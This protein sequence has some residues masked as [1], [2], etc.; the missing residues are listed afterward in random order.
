KDKGLPVDLVLDLMDQICAGVAVA[1]RNAMVHR[2]LKPSNIFLAN[3]SGDS[4]VVKVL[5]FGIAKLVDNPND[6]LTHHG[7]M[8]GSSGYMSPEQITGSSA[9][10]ARTDIY[11]LGGLLYLMLAGPP[12]YTGASTNMIV[13]KQH[14]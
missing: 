1:H 11:A 13:T 10:D 7:A 2:D 8:I 3:L 12:A 5:D 9:I 4:V 14:A 6:G